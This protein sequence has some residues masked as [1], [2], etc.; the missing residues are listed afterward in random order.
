MN[1]DAEL[2]AIRARYDASRENFVAG[3]KIEFSDGGEPE[4]K[5]LHIGTKQDC[6]RVLEMLSGVA[7]SGKRPGA[8]VYRFLI[9]YAELLRPAAKEP[10]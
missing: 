4:V 6:E 9:S 7:Y 2:A 5:F 1:D 10:T 3:Y 8:E